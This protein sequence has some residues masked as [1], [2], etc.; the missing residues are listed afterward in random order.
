MENGGSVK[1]V[2][3]VKWWK[4]MSNDIAGMIDVM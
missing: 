4:M 1:V 3:I 2:V